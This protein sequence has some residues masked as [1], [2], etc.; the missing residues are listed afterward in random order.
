MKFLRKSGYRLKTNP[1]IVGEV[2]ASLEKDGKLTPKELVKASRS[3][4][5][6]L[7][8]E[9]EW[10]DGVAAEKYREFQAGYIIRSVAIEITE[11]SSEVETIELEEAPVVRYYHALERDGNGFENIKTISEDEDKLN[12]LYTTC[13]QDADNFRIKYEVLRDKLPAL[14]EALDDITRDGYEV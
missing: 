11:V 12:K 4:D 8:K 9:F 5:A 3:I 10:R 13:L 6:P 7:H 14:F 2:C 1:Q